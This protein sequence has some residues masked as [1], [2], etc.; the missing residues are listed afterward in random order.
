MARPA[1]N[2]PMAS[3]LDINADFCYQPIENCELY[4]LNNACLK[5]RSG[6]VSI[7]SWSKC[8]VR[9][10]KCFSYSSE[11]ELCA[12]CDDTYLLKSAQ[13]FCYPIIDRCN[14][15]SESGQ[16]VSCNA[17]FTPDSFKRSCVQF[18]A[19]CQLY[20]ITFTTCHTC[21]VPRTRS[22]DGKVC[23]ITISGCSKYDAGFTKCESCQD[24]YSLDQDT[25]N[26]ISRS[27]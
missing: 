27:T 15:Y 18:I 22:A 19:Y 12:A 8:A 14:G 16:C 17:G 4:N 6:Y 24:G 23:Y 2:A 7:A 11:T 5:C 20:D 10:N 26:C 1:K 13:N 25:G 21:S 9:I 3:S